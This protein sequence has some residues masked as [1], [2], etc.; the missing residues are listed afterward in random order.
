MRR[1]IA[2]LLILLGIILIFYPKLKQVYFDYQQKKLLETWTKSLAELDEYDDT[3]SE[4]EIEDN[5][6]EAGSEPKQNDYLTHYI[7]SHMEGILKIEKIKLQI[8]ILKGATKAN[9][10]ISA[11]SI[12]GTGKPGEVGNYSISAHRSRTY[13]RQFNRLDEL[14]KGDRVELIIKEDVIYTYQVFEKL[15]VEAEDTWVMLPQKKEKLLTLITCDYSRKPYPRLV[16]KARLLEFGEN[17]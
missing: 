10:D 7:K 6:I 5:L 15:L 1:F 3:D 14:E 2:S 17:Q 4:P 16:V 11:A 12:E 13:G 9:L 8:P